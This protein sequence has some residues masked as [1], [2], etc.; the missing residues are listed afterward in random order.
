MLIDSLFDLKLTNEM[1]QTI[2]DSLGGLDYFDYLVNTHSNGD[3]TFGNELV[4]TPEIISS[5][6]CARERSLRDGH[7]AAM[8][9]APGHVFHRVMMKPPTPR[10]T[11]P[12]DA[13]FLLRV[14]W[15]NPLCA[16]ASPP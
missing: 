5:V 1:L 14:P 15:M 11:F 6:A 16:T 4:N 2:K 3:H 13:G 9:G 8:E 10:Q 12:G 7:V